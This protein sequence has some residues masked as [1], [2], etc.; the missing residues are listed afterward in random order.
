[1][2]NVFGEDSEEYQTVQYAW[3]YVG[4]TD[5]DDPSTAIHTMAADK[6]SPTGNVWYNLQGLRIDAPSQL[7]VYIHNGKKVVVK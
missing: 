1:M 2:E 3:D 6:A 5:D 4:V 7:G